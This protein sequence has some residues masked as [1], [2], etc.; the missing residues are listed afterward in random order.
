MLFEGLVQ[1]LAKCSRLARRYSALGMVI[2]SHSFH[3]S[4][5]TGRGGQLVGL[6]RCWEVDVLQGCWERSRSRNICYHQEVK[7]NSLLHDH[8][9]CLVQREGEVKNILQWSE[10]PDNIFYG[11]IFKRNKIPRTQRFAFEGVGGFCIGQ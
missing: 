1:I 9:S 10:S 5:V 4:S 3:L 2:R 11:S 8:R 7:H 6:Q